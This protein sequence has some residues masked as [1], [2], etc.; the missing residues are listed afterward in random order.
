MEILIFHQR[1]SPA[2]WISEYKILWAKNFESLGLWNA[3]NFSIL[4]YI[5]DVG[6]DYCLEQS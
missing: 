6:L 4:G 3:K 2:S 1:F 5:K